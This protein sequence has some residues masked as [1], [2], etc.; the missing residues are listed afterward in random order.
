MN[1][2]DHEGAGGA[3]VVDGVETDTGGT[4]FGGGGQS[5]LDLG[6]IGCG[7]E[8]GGRLREEWSGSEKSECREFEREHRSSFGSGGIVLAGGRLLKG[9]AYPEGVRAIALLGSR[10]DGGS[11][12]W[13]R[14]LTLFAVPR[15]VKMMTVLFLSVF[16]FFSQMTDPTL[17]PSGAHV[18]HLTEGRGVQIYDCKRQGS[19]FGWVFQAPEA[20][21][22]DLST[23][24]Q[25]G[26]HGAGPVWIWQDGSSVTG[27]VLVTSP[28]PDSASIPWLLLS[29]T[30][31]GK[32][33]GVL[34]KVTLVRRS[35]THGGS[36][37][38]TGCDVEHV[39][40]S[41]R[42]PYTARYSF[43]SVP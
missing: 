16:L 35:E 21:L 17:P 41:L 5:G 23:Q 31:S 39:G 18:V 13:V 8:G 28:S 26:T 33:A 30:P 37:P 38:G 3:E 15:L 36:A 11:E 6:E 12:R 10:E 40:Q 20:K 2:D 24:K 22:F 14:S 19:G 9:L 27:K 32:P 4:G 1:A 7:V 34:S 29:A 25:V 43:Y 42:V